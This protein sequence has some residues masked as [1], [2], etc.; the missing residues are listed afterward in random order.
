MHGHATLWLTVG[1]S[2]LTWLFTKIYAARR[3]VWRLQ[4]AGLP[5]PKFGLLTGHLLT[6]KKNLELFPSNAVVQYAFWQM[7]KQFPS[8]IFYVNMWPFSGTL[9]V[10]TTP[11]GATQATALDLNVCP[12][13]VSPI[14]A[15]TGGPSLLSMSIGPEWKRWRRAFNPGFSPGY[16]MGLAPAIADEVAVFRKLLLS[17]CSS[18]T[19]DIFQLEELTLKMTFDIIASVTLDARLRYQTQDNSLA[20][21]LRT[22]IDWTSFGTELNPFKRYLAI[23]PIIQW[24][25]NRRID[26]YISKEID[27]RFA[28]RLEEQAQQT[29]LKRSKSVVALLMEELLQ[30]VTDKDLSQVKE[31]VKKTMA[32]QLRAF[33]FAGLETT[34]STLLYCYYLLSA[35]QGALDRVMAEHNEI[36]GHDADK[37]HEAIY[38]DPQRL[39]Q[40]PYTVAVIKE[41]L[42]IFPPAA[43]MRRGRAGAEIVDEEGRRYPT[44]GCNVWTSTMAIHNDP[45]WWEDADDFKPERWLVGA[46]DPL[47]PV[48]G[49]WLPFYWGPKSC[50]GQTLV[51]LELRIALVMTL[52]EL[53]ITPAYE[54]WDSLHAKSGIR[55]ASGDRAYQAQ[56]GGGGTSPHPADGLP[57]KVALRNL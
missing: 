52:R 3:P 34:S 35:N 14:E 31:T 43:P 33:L 50:I 54:E 2:A 51:M 49:A 32:P 13:V 10:I 22:Q 12:E 46:E 17:R 44:E 7:S 11:S 41:V 57:V 20:T 23:R 5:M 28:E 8:G 19:S 30:E 36:F 6:L 42:R 47:Y 40:L 37:A 4:Q 48:K 1:I 9:L 27:Q 29:S 16:M 25:N 45:R 24:V 21:A 55:I 15:I 56:D 26:N 39:N 18:G 38:Q 53:T